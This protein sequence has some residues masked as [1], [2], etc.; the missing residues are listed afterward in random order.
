MDISIIWTIISFIIIFMVIVIAHEGGH[1]IIAKANGIDVAEFT[2]GVGPK[3]FG[4][5]IKDT[6]YSLRALPFGGA[7]IFAGEDELEDDEEKEKKNK[8]EE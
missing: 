7:C 4:F 6:Y 1:M 2:V 3:L 5:H 8:C